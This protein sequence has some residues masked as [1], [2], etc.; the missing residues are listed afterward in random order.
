MRRRP[1]LRT[2]AASLAVLAAGCLGD[3]GDQSSGETTQASTTEQ[4]TTTTTTTSKES[5]Y[6]SAFRGFLGSVDVTILRLAV[7]SDSPVVELEY[8]TT[9]S[10]SNQLGAEIGGIAGGYFRQVREGWEMD[11]LDATIFE[12]ADSPVA[13]WHAKTA[14]FE[15]YQNGDLASEDLSLRV[16]DTLE[17]VEE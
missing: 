9:K 13:T 1:L 7:R 14:W 4:T 11:R 5:D 10:G 8:V 17:P 6:L 15:A 16:L 2:G 12:G 3:G